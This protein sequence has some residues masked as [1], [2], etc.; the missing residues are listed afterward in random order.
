MCVCVFVC[1]TAGSHMI[2]DG[3]DCINLATFNLLGF[4]EH[5]KVKVKSIHC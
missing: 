4:L 5:P 1:S 3:K 2:V